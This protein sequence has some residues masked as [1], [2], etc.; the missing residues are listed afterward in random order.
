V[1]LS[2]I[3]LE[4]RVAI[5]TGDSRGIGKAISLTLAEAGADIVLVART[6]EQFRDLKCHCNPL[7]ADF[8]WSKPVNF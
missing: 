6:R 2:C 3:S 5:V 8:M 4:N 1:G 7:L